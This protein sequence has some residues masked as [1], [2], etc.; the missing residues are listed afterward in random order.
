MID[1][2]DFRTDTEILSSSTG[3]IDV[4]E[5]EKERERDGGEICVQNECLMQ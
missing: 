2:F 3:D 4:V 1:L 5:R